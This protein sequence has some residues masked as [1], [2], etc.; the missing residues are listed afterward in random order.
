MGLF[1]RKILAERPDNVLSFAG[2][3]FDRAELG[4]VVGK[5]IVE[6]KQMEERNKWLNDLI[7]GKTLIE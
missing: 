3:F 1:T 6:E 2:R 5:A 7:K 4:E